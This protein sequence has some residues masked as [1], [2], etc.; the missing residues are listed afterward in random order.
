MP[1]KEK[2]IEKI[3]W[4]IGEVSKLLDVSISMI[5]FWETELGIFKPKKN[6]K[7]DRFF[8]KED[9]EKIKLVHYLTKEKGYTLKG[10]KQKIL[11]EGIEKAETELQTLETLKKIR[12]FLSQLKS[13]L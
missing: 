4:S 8:T 1:Y 3:Y 9:L 10:A 5:R 11:N 13:E 12:T 2:N 7:G 6:K